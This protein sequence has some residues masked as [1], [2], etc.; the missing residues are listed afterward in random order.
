MFFSSSYPYYLTIGLQAICVIHCLR[1][2]NANK[3]IW[4]IVFLPF[5]GSLAYLYTEMFSRQDVSKVQHGVGALFNPGGNLKKLEQNL[6]FSDT[7]KNRVTLADAYLQA[8]YIDKAIELY[9]SS[10]TGTFEE[11]EYV[12]LQ[13]ITAYFQKERYADVLPIVKKIQHLPQFA[14][15]KVHL[16]YARAL[17]YTGNA[18]Q[19]VQQFKMMAARF[20]NYEARY[21]YSLLL[22]ETGR[23]DEAHALLAAI[24][25][26]Q[27]HLSSIERRDNRKWLSLAKEKLKQLAV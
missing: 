10:L 20:A 15:S 21:Y 6:H 3:W 13:L 7:F 11:N 23:T 14:R 27:P 26:E 5:I 17:Q 18:A 19:S 9:Q 16:L 4:I 8:G 1:K 25:D 2:G 22:L 24:V 12:L